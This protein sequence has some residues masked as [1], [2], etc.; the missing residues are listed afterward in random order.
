MDNRILKKVYK[1]RNKKT[2]LFS[3]GGI[4]PKWSKIGKL[5][6]Q[7]SHLLLHLKQFSKYEAE[8][9]YKNCEIVCYEMKECNVVSAAQFKRYYK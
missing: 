1:I 4:K 2:G 3:S 5:W 7:K 9:I 8:K 6:T